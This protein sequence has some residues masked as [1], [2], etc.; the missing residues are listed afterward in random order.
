MF[1]AGSDASA[2]TAPHLEIDRVAYGFVAE[3]RDPR[4]FRTG[5]GFV[6]ANPWGQ[7]TAY[8]MLTDKHGRRTW[9]IEHNLPNVGAGSAQGSTMYLLEGSKRALLIDTANPAKATEGVSDLKTVVRY[10]LGHDD[11]GKAKAR[12]LDFVVAN[13]HNHP[14]H[15]GE[16]APD[17]RPYRLLHGW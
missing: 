17:E 9:R 13:T 7:Y 10:L 16:N 8:L 2:A 15:I 6:A 1:G 14:D 3:T 12:P 11:A 4:G 5:T